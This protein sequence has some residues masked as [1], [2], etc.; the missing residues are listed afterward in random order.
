MAWQHWRMIQARNQVRN[1]KTED[2]CNNRGISLITQM[3]SAEPSGF[4]H[5]KMPNEWRL[6]LSLIFACQEHNNAYS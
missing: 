5:L 6:T 4:N 3:T 1:I 2:E